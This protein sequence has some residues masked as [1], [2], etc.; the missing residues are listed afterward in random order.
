MSNWYCR[1]PEVGG[2]YWS[3]GFCIRNI[4]SFHVNIRDSEGHSSAL[5]VEILQQEC[6]FCVVFSDASGFPPPF[7]VDNLAQVPIIFHQTDVP[8]AFL[9]T[10]VS[11][12][13]SGRF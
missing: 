8:E 3:G 9:H 4:S 2:C 1:L 6:T 13:I 12:P 11:Y 10:T 5:R 7:R